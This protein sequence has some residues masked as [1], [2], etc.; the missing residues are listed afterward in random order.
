MSISSTQQLD[1]SAG[2]TTV[3]AWWLYA[4]STPLGKDYLDSGNLGRATST[5]VSNLPNGTTAF[6]TLWYR[7]ASDRW[8]SRLYQCDVE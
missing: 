2:D 7:N 3:S 5:T 1:W 4:G 6:I 8:Q